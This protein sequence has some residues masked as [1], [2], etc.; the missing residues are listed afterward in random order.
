MCGVLLFSLFTAVS[1]R[2]FFQGSCHSFSAPSML[3][4]EKYESFV[5]CALLMNDRIWNDDDPNPNH[6]PALV[7]APPVASVSSDAIDVIWMSFLAFYDDNDDDAWL[8]MLKFKVRVKYLVT[9]RR[10]QE[11]C[12]RNLYSVKRP[13]R[14]PSLA[15][16]SSSFSFL[17]R[18]SSTKWNDT[19]TCWKTACTSHL[20]FYVISFLIDKCRSHI[21]KRYCLFDPCC[22]LLVYTC[23]A[24]FVCFYG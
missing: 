7:C 10:W 6:N 23:V 17:S 4:I 5:L 2:L 21:R 13:S 24:I 15:A 20:S 22:L 8:V 3:L 9:T 16:V 14:H 19:F 12:Q 1:Y 11:L 18:V